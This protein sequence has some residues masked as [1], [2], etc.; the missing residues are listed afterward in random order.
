MPDDCHGTLQVADEAH[1][2]CLSC[3]GAGAGHKCLIAFWAFADV[4]LA[5]VPEC[6]CMESLLEA[7]EP[8]AV[9]AS[10]IAHCMVPHS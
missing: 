6:M 8:S 4:S 10:M 9:G 1:H 5:T 3:V 2:S 7:F